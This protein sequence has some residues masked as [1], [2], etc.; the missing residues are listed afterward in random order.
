MNAC[1]DGWLEELQ[2]VLE[3]LNQGVIISD[4]TGH[5]L[6]ANSTMLLHL[7][8]FMIRKLSCEA[9]CFILAAVP[10]E[11]QVRVL[12]LA[13]AGHSP[14]VVVRVGESPRLLES[15]SPLAGNRGLSN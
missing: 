11:S 6:F 5:I 9:F 13:G 3:M 12:Q 2:S 1:P 15:C 4:E 8:R 10:I 7:N 14:A